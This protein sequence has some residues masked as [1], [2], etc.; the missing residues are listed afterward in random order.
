MKQK[1]SY[2]VESLSSKKGEL[3]RL[4]LQANSGL[5]LEQELLHKSGL[6]PSM[7]VLDLGC[8]NGIV[9]NQ[10]SKLLKD[11]EVVGMDRSDELFN[12]AS[13]KYLDVPNLSFVK[14]DVYA[15]PFQNE[16]FDFVYAR[17][18]FQHLVDPLK[19][20]LEIK[21]VLKPEGV[22]S[23]IDVDDSWLMTHP[24]H[25]TFER[26]KS[27]AAKR[28]RELGGDRFIGRKF[29][30]YFEQAGFQIFNTEIRGVS[31]LDLGTKDFLTITTSFKFQQLNP[32]QKET[33]ADDYGQMIEDLME[34]GY[35]LFAGVFNGVAKKE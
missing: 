13:R 20:L 3:D 10:L 16:S 8:G 15:L 29:N 27:A 31:D 9:S 12:L 25:Q 28:Q 22:V 1:G 35:S 19:A 24:E 26:L 17:F 23:L 30:N 21:R 5:A 14:G 6:T 33:F 2:Q 7:K 32:D 11:G 4:S 34:G 18:L